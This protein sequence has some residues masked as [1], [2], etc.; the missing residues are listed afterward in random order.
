MYSDRI[1]YNLSKNEQELMTLILGAVCSDGVCIVADKKFTTKHNTI[2]GYGDKI[3]GEIENV[4]FGA[5]GYRRLFEEFKIQIRKDLHDG[6]ISRDDVIPQLAA[7]VYEINQ[8]SKDT[9]TDIFDVVVS[10]QYPNEK[11]STLSY[12]DPDGMIIPVITRIPTGSGNPH[13][14]YFLKRL[15]QKEMTMKE[16]AILSWFIIKYIEDNQLDET[17]G[18]DNLEPQIYYVEHK[19]KIDRNPNPAELKEIKKAVDGAFRKFDE[20]VNGIF[21]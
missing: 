9:R 4:V 1:V 14:R 16:F 7:K 18:V 5:S 15:Y 8:T 20:H 19:G 6:K 17:V 2:A 10:R 11:E 3:F 21:N 12:I 13:A